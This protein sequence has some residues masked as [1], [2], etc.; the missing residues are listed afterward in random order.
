LSYKLEA[1]KSQIAKKRKRLAPTVDQQQLQ[2]SEQLFQSL[3]ISPQI[4]VTLPEETPMKIVKSSVAI[5][6]H[7]AH[8]C[9]LPRQLNNQMLSS[10]QQHQQLQQYS[11]FNV[12]Y[13]QTFAA[14]TKPPPPPY[15]AHY[16]K[17]QCIQPIS[18]DYYQY[19]SESNIPKSRFNHQLQ[20][21]EQIE[22]PRPPYVEY[23]KPP[24]Y[25][26]S[27]ERL[28]THTKYLSNCSDQSASSTMSSTYTSPFSTPQ[29]KDSLNNNN[30][31]NQNNAELQTSFDNQ[32][33]LTIDEQ[34]IEEIRIKAASMS[35][36]L[37]TALCSDKSL[38][39]CLSNKQDS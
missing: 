5:N 24:S 4:Q 28:K 21:Q 11:T 14:K 15:N 36:P 13:R 33:E 23:K 34:N 17:K 35:L 2:S 27:L 37:L 25:E 8:S 39:R 6:L 20:Q 10:Y 7:S 16:A 31:N 3:K 18:Q 26:E 12:D 22:Q 38:L 19:Y 29:R 32:S 9:C 30:N 1:N